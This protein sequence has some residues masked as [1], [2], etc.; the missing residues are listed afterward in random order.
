[1]PHFLAAENDLL[2]AEAMLMTSGNS[3][4]V[5]ALINNTRVGRGA[6]TPLDGTESTAVALDA[7]D[8]ERYVELA[9]TRGGIQYYNCHQ[10]T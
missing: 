4:A 1:M 3:A 2:K 8:H 6:M 9:V 10:Y 5:A 7:V